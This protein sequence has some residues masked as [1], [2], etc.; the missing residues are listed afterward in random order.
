LFY[1]SKSFPFSQ[2]TG[3]E[4]MSKQNKTE[5]SSP[6][7]MRDL[8]FE[9]QIGTVVR[10]EDESSWCVTAI[11][12][13]K[14]EYRL[15]GVE[16]RGNYGEAMTMTIAAFNHT[17]RYLFNFP[18]NH[19]D[20]ESEPG[21]I[22]AVTGGTLIL[23]RVLN[24]PKAQ[25]YFGEFIGM[26]DFTIVKKALTTIGRNAG[27]DCWINDQSVSRNHAE[28]HI[29]DGRFFLVDLFSTNKTYLN[30]KPLKSGEETELRYR[31]TVRFGNVEFEFRE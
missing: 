14:Q 12:N 8:P 16:P 24:R 4:T 23:N 2:G 18:V 7:Y 6:K 29:R 30:E 20:R 25:S 22:K 5:D 10:L 26:G 1:I 13:N 27:N 21:V 3:V 9:A 17:A 19:L 31:D 28:I 11:D 15:G